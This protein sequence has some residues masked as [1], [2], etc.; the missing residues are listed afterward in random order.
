MKNKIIAFSGLDGAGKS[1]QIEFLKKEFIA[2]DKKVFIFWSRIGYT[3][4]FQTIK[5]LLRIIFKKNIP[6]PGNSSQRKKAFNNKF[7]K[8]LWLFISFIDL[9]FYYSIYLRVKYFLGY[10]IIL[11]RYIIDSEIDLSLNF[12]KF[13]YK[14]SMLWKTLKYCAIKPHYNFL[15]LISV[16]DSIIRS[17]K[18]N[19]PFPDSKNSLSLR[20]DHYKNKFSKKKYKIIWCNRDVDEIRKEIN[21]CF[22]R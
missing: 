20:L 5:D 11:D 22:E 12:S 10:N 19:E 2:L 21:S 13:N 4:T 9:I 8:R 6:K 7:I 3:Y 16:E 17:K 14:K 15:L 18:K 1:T